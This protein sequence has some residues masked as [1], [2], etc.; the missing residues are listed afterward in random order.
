MPHYCY[1]ASIVAGLC[2]PTSTI[3]ATTL[4][5][6]HAASL[7]QF[8]IEANLGSSIQHFENQALTN[9]MTHGTAS[10]NEPAEDFPS[11]PSSYRMA[12]GLDAGW[13]FAHQF[14]LELGVYRFANTTIT[15]SRTTATAF[16]LH[17]NIDSWLSYAALKLT[18]F[19]NIK[20]YFD[21]FAKI[22]IS[23]NN[24]SLTWSGTYSGQ[25]NNN[26]FDALIGLGATVNFSDCIYGSAQALYVLRNTEHFDVPTNTMVMATLGFKF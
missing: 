18:M 2:L 13:V 1:Y 6:P 14:S 12:Y 20:Q 5:A 25:K 4:P 21:L 16:T 8:Y 15:A 23:Y 3:L 22:G 26:F 10:A 17:G 9:T 11:S 24:N 19:T 7:P